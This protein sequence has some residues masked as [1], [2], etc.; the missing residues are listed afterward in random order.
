MSGRYACMPPYKVNGDSARE[1]EAEID[2]CQRSL[3]GKQ[4][5]DIMEAIGDQY[6]MMKTSSRRGVG[7]DC[8]RGR[9]VTSVMLGTNRFTCC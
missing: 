8:D 1:K 7:D 3:R 9:D 6:P 5:N 4:S 2:P